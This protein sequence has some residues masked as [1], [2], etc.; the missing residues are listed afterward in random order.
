MSC[1]CFSKAW[2]VG[3]R[4]RD[5]CGAP[6]QR[7]YVLPLR[8]RW[9]SPVAVEK[10]KHLR[11]GGLVSVLTHAGNQAVD[12]VE[13]LHLPRADCRSGCRCE[14]CWRDRLGS[15]VEPRLGCATEASLSVASERRWVS[16]GCHEFLGLFLPLPRARSC[17]FVLALPCLHIPAWASIIAFEFFMNFRPAFI[18][19]RFQESGGAG[20][21]PKAIR[22]PPKTSRWFRRTVARLPT[23]LPNEMR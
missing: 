11:A 7:C 17:G 16:P 10:L 23:T 13:R 15:G 22:I 14:A 9:R 8:G 4:H 21:L 5:S 3:R 19:G 20:T 1:K 18:V 6:L 2:P 12:F